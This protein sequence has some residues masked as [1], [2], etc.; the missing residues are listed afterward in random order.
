MIHIICLEYDNAIEKEE[1]IN[2]LND[3]SLVEDNGCNLIFA[4]R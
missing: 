1:M 2:F 4:R 3:F